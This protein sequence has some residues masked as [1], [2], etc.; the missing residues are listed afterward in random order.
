MSDSTPEVLAR[1][2][3]LLE[4]DDPEAL[5]GV[6]AGLHPADIAELL[7]EMENEQNVR[8]L[9]HLGNE[10]AAEVLAM[11]DER[12]GQEL[13]K[14]LSDTEVVSLLGEMP[15]DDV[16]DIISGLP[17][18]KSRQI[19]A[20]LPS[21]E[22]EK[23]HELLEFDEDTAG[24]I[25]EVEK[26]AV[27]ES[28][29]IRDAIE[30]VRRL[31]DQIENLQNVYAVDRDGVLV[32]SIPVLGLLLHEQGER[33]SDLMDRNVIGVPVDMDQEEVAAMFGK[34]DEFTLPVVDSGGRLVGRITVDDIIDVLEEEASE[35]IARIAGT[36]ED[37]ISEKSPVR[38]SRARL[39]WLV[40]GMLGQIINAMNMSR[41]SASLETMVTL[42]FF[43]PLVIGTAGNMG[44]QAAVVVVRQIAVGQISTTHMG[45]RVLREM[46]VTVMNSVVLGAILFSVVTLWRHETGLGLLLW[47]TLMGVTLVGA[48]MGASIPL[49]LNRLRVDPAIATGPFI[50]VL[51]DILGLLIY[52]TFATYYLSHLGP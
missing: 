1:V 3:D 48:F 40:I 35:D 33:V 25:M 6:L 17:P 27:R 39:P 19:D 18:E 14:L 16:A 42:A 32:G 43:I 26:V 28:A 49:V 10:T 7:A 51:S 34:Y 37:E 31:A 13:L 38:I 46:M 20:L 4:G 45:R 52:M 30:L 5:R 29:S 15:S 21:G 23:L 8:V 2:R 24:G 12:S 50:T 9:K 22:R 36:V 41:Y 44:M 11:V 47:I